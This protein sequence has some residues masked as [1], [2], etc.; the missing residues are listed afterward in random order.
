VNVRGLLVN[1][2]LIVCGVTLL[3]AACTLAPTYHAPSVPLPV[4]AFKEA[5]DWLPA[6]PGDTQAR[7]AWWV[8]FGEPKLNELERTLQDS[9]PDVR[10]ALARLEQARAI[11]LGARSA[12]LPS[13][14]ADASAKREHLSANAP[15]AG[16]GETF[17][18]FIAGL[19]LSWEIDVFGR[20]RSEANAAG[21]R[22]EASNADLAALTLSLEAE[23]ANDYFTL[24]GADAQL[25]LLEDTVR[26]YDRAYELTRDR[27]D[28]A[29]AAA[30]D[31]DQADTQRQNARAQLAA[32]RL[33]RAQLE[34]A[35]A[36]LLGAVPSAFSLESGTL[37]GAPPP[38]DAGLP[39]TL[40]QRRPDVASA[41][42]AVAAANAEIGAARA[43]WFPVFTLTGSGGFESS[44]TSNWLG[45]PSR[46][47]SVGPSGQVPLLDFGARSAIT[48]H[49]WAVYDES[50]ANYRKTTLT[51]YQEV[52]DN[53][54]ALHHL[55]DE[56][57]ADEAASASAQR[58]AY[59]ADRRYAAGVA[60]Y[61]EVTTT[62]TTALQAER[63]AL[64]A[65]VAR[66][67]AA[68]GLV[69]ATGGGWGRE[70][71][72]LESSR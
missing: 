54:A 44:S 5:G 26:T 3:L 71:L 42:R 15:V 18:D 20:L 45:A 32:V 17:N 6:L 37:A 8:A 69:R 72:A 22:V 57:A 68:V 38:I 16:A 24:R 9:N 55:A 51:A 14:S 35:I 30:T 19:N 59:H 1:V 61:I 36:V 67:N 21:A 10:G 4:E 7:G 66:I 34:H 2:R 28:G 43:A 27:Y 64:D 11:A 25:R 58:A 39:S 60:D 13:V 41:E 52:E 31:V 47:W 33:Q 63:A 53:L 40:L 62:Q 70:Q 23:L 12:T 46:F 48:R 50:V 56:L 49:A 65:R 29:I